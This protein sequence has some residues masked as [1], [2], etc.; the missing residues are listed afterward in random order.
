[1]SK[2]TLGNADEDEPDRTADSANNS[3]TLPALKNYNTSV[4]ESSVK[5]RLKEHFMIQN[6][7]DKSPDYTALAKEITTGR[8]KK[9]PV[10]LLDYHKF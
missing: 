10:G 5:K 2:E 1:M 4:F 3:Q 8:R 9:S 7:Y 6:M